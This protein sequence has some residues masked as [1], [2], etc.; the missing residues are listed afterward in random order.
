MKYGLLIFDPIGGTEN[1]GDYI[2][3]L[4][5]KQFINDDIIYLDREHLNEYN[6]EKII[7]I[8]NGWFMHLPYNFPPSNNIIPYFI[9]FHLNHDVI[10]IILNNF[11]N[12]S[13]IKK[14]EPIGCRD[15]YTLNELTKK[16]IKAYFSGC[17]TLTLGNIY[18]QTTQRQGIYFVDPYICKKIR[19]YISMLLYSKF[20][21]NFHKIYQISKLK[22]KNNNLSSLI[23]SALFYYQYSSIWPDEIILNSEYLEHS[24]KFVNHDF[25]FYYADSLLKKYSNAKLIITSRIHA[26]LPATG[27]NTPCIFVLPFNM[28]K[29]SK[30]RLVGLIELLNVVVHKGSKIKNIDKIDVI[31][32]R[33]KSNYL[34]IKEKLITKMY[35]LSENINN[36]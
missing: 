10:K 4:A 18:K 29:S 5:A 11:N 15:I 8:L 32:P 13:Y 26:A 1:T 30:S 3:S 28:S 17:L 27:M 9:S 6:G 36:F 19:S 21:K 14:Y 31:N 23:S 7:L 24:L 25:H 34:E 12:I 2:Q 20:I 33:T 22:Y 16:G 35:K